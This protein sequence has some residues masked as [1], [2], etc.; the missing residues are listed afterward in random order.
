MTNKKDKV[1]NQLNFNFLT[2]NVRG[3]LCTKKRVKMLE[4]LKSKIGPKGILFLQETHSLTD[5]EK[6]WKEEFKGK[7][8]FSHGKTNSCGVLI[9]F[10]G[11][12]NVVVKNQFKDD[13]G[14]ILILEVTIYA[15][16]Y[17]S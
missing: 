11:N 17:L 9:A 3:M 15:T 2:N 14:R 6:Q 10:F 4:Y 8:Y 12:S 7:L 13:H 5:S 1:P 16:E